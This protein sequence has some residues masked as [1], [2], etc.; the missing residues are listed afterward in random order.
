MLLGETVTS[1]NRYK[2]L[3]IGEKQVPVDFFDE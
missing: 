3:E 1:W 2:I